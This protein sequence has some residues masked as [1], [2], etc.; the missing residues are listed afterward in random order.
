MRAF[1]EGGNESCVAGE[2]W[3]GS[4]A[5]GWKRIALFSWGGSASALSPALSSEPFQQWGTGGCLLTWESHVRITLR[6]QTENKLVTLEWVWP[7]GI[8][9]PVVAEVFISFPWAQGRG[10]LSTHCCQYCAPSGEEMPSLD[11][12][13]NNFDVYLVWMKFIHLSG[14]ESILPSSPQRRNT[15]ALVAKFF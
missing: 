3:G 6:E 5:Q 7:L 15:A 10:C 11:L 1:L 9:S 4:V 14:I 8:A 13:F 12:S 2:P